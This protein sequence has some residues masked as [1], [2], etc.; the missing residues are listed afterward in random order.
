MLGAAVLLADARALG[1]LKI[2]MM[3]VTHASARSELL[4]A[5]TAEN[6]RRRLAFRTQDCRKRVALI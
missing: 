6:A 4:A 1:A 2:F 3:T 5:V